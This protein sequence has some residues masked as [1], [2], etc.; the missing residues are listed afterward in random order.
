MS[1]F[2]MIV[3]R[4]LIIFYLVMFGCSLLEDYAFLM[5]EKKGVEPEGMGGG[6]VLGEIE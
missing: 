5:R 6:E 3:L 2:N 1:N 4:H